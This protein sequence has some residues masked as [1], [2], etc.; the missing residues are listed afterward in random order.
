MRV[1]YSVKPAIFGF[2][3]G[4]GTTEQIYILR[5]IIE[6]ASEWRSNLYIL[7]VDYEK[8]FDSVHRETLW[9]IL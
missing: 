8:A 5:N 7:F 4:R 9:K 6:Q 1:I 2:R 3:K